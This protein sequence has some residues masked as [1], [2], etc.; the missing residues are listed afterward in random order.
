MDIHQETEL[1]SEYERLFRIQGATGVLAQPMIDGT[2]LFLGAKREP[3]FGFLV[4]CGLGGIFV[5]GLGDVA[6]GLGRQTLPEARRMW[7][8]LRG[9]ALLRGARGRPAVDEEAL[10]RCLVALSELLIVAPEIE[11]IDINPLFA[12]GTALV[13]ADARARLEPGPGSKG[14]SEARQQKALD[15]RGAFEQR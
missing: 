8:K 9:R 11:E 7:Q 15:G 4:A 6:W 5:E 14:E 2:E 12:K 1:L 3:A 10:A 13:A